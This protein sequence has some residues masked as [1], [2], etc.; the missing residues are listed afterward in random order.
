MKNGEVGKW[1]WEGAGEHH[2]RQRSAVAGKSARGARSRRRPDP[3]GGVRRR[4]GQ[5]GSLQGSLRVELDGGNIQADNIGGNAVQVNVGRCKAVYVWN[6][7]A[8][9]VSGRPATW[10]AMPSRPAWRGWMRPGL[11]SRGKRQRPPPGM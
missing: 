7:M 10:G 5:R 2:G 1:T 6:S 9:G 3:Q 11:R 8:A 4:P